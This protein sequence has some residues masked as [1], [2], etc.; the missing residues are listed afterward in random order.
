MSAGDLSQPSFG[1]WLRRRRHELDLTQAQFARQVGCS[2]VMLHKLETEERRPSQAMAERLAELLKVPRAD[3]PA[4]LRFARG[5]PFAAPESSKN[6]RDSGAPRHNLPVQLTSFIGREKDLAAVRALARSTRLVTLTGVGGVGKTRLALQAA[7]GLLAQFPGGAWMVEMASQTDAALVPDAVAGVL[8]V[9]EQAGRPVLAT[10]IDHLR[11]RTILLIL[12]NCEHLVA[13]CA[14][15]AAALLAGCPN[16]TILATSRETLGIP[17]EALF[18]VP[19]LPAP[20]ARH[21]LLP[22]AFIHYEAVRL[23]VERASAVLSGFAVTGENAPAVAHVCRQLDGIPL[24]IELA[25]ARVRVLRVEQIA[26]RLD[27]RFRL[28]T[29]GSRAALPRHQTL[30]ALIDWS[31]DLLAPVERALLRRLAVFV[32]G[33]T[34]P[35]AEATCAGDGLDPADVLDLLV[36][37]VNK[38]LVA[39]E[40]QPGQD[41]RYRL[42]DTIRHYALARLA[43]SGEAESVWRRLAQYYIALIKVSGL[44]DQIT[45]IQDP[46]RVLAQERDNVRGA[47]A[48]CRSAPGAEELGLQLAVAVMNSWIGHGDWREAQAFLEAALE[49]ASQLANPSARVRAEL[50]LGQIAYMQGHYARATAHLLRSSSLAR[51][52]QD[53]RA[54]GAAL[55]VLADVALEQ[56]EPPLALDHL[57]AAWALYQRLDDAEGMAVTMQMQAEAVLGQEDAVRAA[58]LFQKSLAL[59]PEPV[60]ANHVPGTLIGLGSTAILQGDYELAQQQYMD[61]LALCR[62]HQERSLNLPWAIYGLGEA[63]LGL[64]EAALARNHFREALELFRDEG[65]QGAI[66]F[67]LASLGC[68]AA[69]AGE[70][71]QAA[72]LWGMAD[73]LRK[74]LGA[75]QPPASRVIRERLVDQTRKQLGEEAFAAAWTE[76][77]QLS[78][79]QAIDLAMSAG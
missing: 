1:N 31:Y 19:P 32:G 73:A 28:L 74:S 76:G 52:R 25:A 33:W 5:D 8:G 55:V 72:G 11:G 71:A 67:C 10:L 79:E 23:F 9:K 4:F 66:S 56:G 68:A 63:T 12:D 42:L 27:D 13:A 24:A 44:A 77:A 34:L 51:E 61:C 46:Y 22:E 58:A 40:H 38:S 14:R 49:R 50:G 30:Q 47:L 17:G 45:S 35:A 2:T 48:W 60:R 78:L 18:V 53:A 29:G 39:V 69:L 64:G 41:A 65:D 6:Q 16:L 70:L 7:D 21:S 15:L 26:E 57:E 43:E 75:R 20:H 36:Q 59:F 37:L 3:R 62:Q 54:E